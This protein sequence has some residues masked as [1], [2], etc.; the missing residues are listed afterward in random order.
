MLRRVFGMAMGCVVLMGAASIV[1]GEDKPKFTIKEV[2]QEAH[3]GGLLK[4]VA[5]G[6]A[7]KEEKEKLV[8]YYTA[9]SQGK[10]PKG[11]DKEWKEATKAMVEAAK[12]AAKDDQ[13]ATAKLKKMQGECKTCHTKFKS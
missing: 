4:K 13:E 5:S 1:L 7:S 10:P 6:K 9:L 12:G 8:E 2:M 11:E 3:K